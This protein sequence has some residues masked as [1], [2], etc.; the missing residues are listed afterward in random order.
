M[1]ANSRFLDQESSNKPATKSWSM[2][3]IRFRRTHNRESSVWQML[4]W[5]KT[6][7][8]RTFGLFWAPSKPHAI[9][10]SAVKL[11]EIRHLSFQV[12]TAS[13]GFREWRTLQG[14]SIGTC[15]QP[16]EQTN[17]CSLPHPSTTLLLHSAGWA[18][19]LLP[20]SLA[21]APCGTP[22]QSSPT[23]EKSSAPHISFRASGLSEA[24]CPD[25]LYWNHCTFVGILGTANVVMRPF[26]SVSIRG[27]CPI[28]TKQQ[29][30][31]ICTWRLFT[32][33]PRSKS[34]PKLRKSVAKACL[35]PI[36]CSCSLSLSLSLA[37]QGNRSV[38]ADCASMSPSK[39]RVRSG[40]CAD[41]FPFSPDLHG[42]PSG[43]IL[44]QFL[45]I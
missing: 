39:N 18:E 16:I 45:G 30:S 10:L 25:Y 24:F 13:R 20:T 9:L 31:P 27:P 33:D 2:R 40:S 21:T 26:S 3:E 35:A 37:S 14:R 17:S 1:L 5:A 4:P 23:L 42:T 38:A 15:T 19:G 6:V 28:A 22:G 43:K 36:R 32:T 44:G 7:L 29:L 11:T 41:C 12:C 8:L 34:S